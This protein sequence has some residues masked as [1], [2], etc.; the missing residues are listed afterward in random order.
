MA[1]SLGSSTCAVQDAH[2]DA[3]AAEHADARLAMQRAA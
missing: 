1:A 3:A 2:G